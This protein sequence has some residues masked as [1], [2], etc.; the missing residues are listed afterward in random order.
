MNL[1]RY[2][3]PTASKAIMAA[4][5]VGGIVIGLIARSFGCVLIARV[6][7]TIA[8]LP[9]LCVTFL[10]VNNGLAS[11]QWTTYCRRQEPV[12]F[13]IVFSILLAGTFVWFASA[14][15]APMN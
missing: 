4:I 8:G 14:W 9:L 13:W 15:L 11:T 7:V 5:L 3:L 12:R 6:G 10:I 2:N 1:D